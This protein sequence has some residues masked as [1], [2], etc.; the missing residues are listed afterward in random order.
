MH[1]TPID[2][3]LLTVGEL[4]D[5]SNAIYTVPIYQRNYAWQAEQI[6]QLLRDIQDAIRDK[7][8]SYFLG[9]LM[10]TN[11]RAVSPAL[12]SSTA[13]N[14]LL[15]FIC[16]RPSWLKAAICCNDRGGFG[17]SDSSLSGKAGA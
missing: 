7:E 11:C 8:S 3:R 15:L 4:F 17:N 9:N 1:N 16:C 5:D 10:V 12:K 14:D 6:E 2:P 13:S